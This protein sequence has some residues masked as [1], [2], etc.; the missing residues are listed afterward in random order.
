MKS[1][2]VFGWFALATLAT[3]CGGKSPTGPPGPGE[4]H[5]VTAVAFYDED[6]SGRLEAGEDSRL[7]GVTVSIAGRTARTENVTG[8]AVV[9][10]VPAGAQTAELRG[11]LAFFR[12]GAPVTVNVPA[13][14]ELLLA[15]TLPIGGNRP[16]T[17]MAFGDSI[18]V[19]EGS[20]NSQ[21]YT[22]PL[23]RALRGFF[24]KATILNEGQSGT[25]SSAGA[26]RIGGT[27]RRHRP[28]YTLIMYGTNDWNECGNAVPCYTIDS[29]RR[30]VE[31]TK[32]ATSL[33]VLATILPA[34]PAFGAEARNSWVTKMNELV[35]DLAQEQDALL[36]DVDAAF[37][38]QPDL[39]QLF[40][41]HI[42]PND[43][44]YA[45]MA[46]EFFKAITQPSDS[47]TAFSADF[48]GFEIAPADEPL[49]VEAAPGGSALA[50]PGERSRPI[51]GE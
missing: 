25:R 34:N 10:G 37:R 30:I 41:D 44:G 29:L 46:E 27:L 13:T 5:A 36:V 28:A 26:S 49:A 43:R 23:E 9:N 40:E 18:T 15:A 33:P 31:K 17:Y 11:L 2:L 12:P 45:I 38:R 42:H 3:A 39:R 48:G 24:G 6:G 22:V 14:G 47:S 16:H 50:A 8:R 21:G 19:G 4:T 7:G 1:R 51:R 20:R 32:S 35:R